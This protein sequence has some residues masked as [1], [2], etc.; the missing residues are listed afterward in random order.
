MVQD[1][2]MNTPFY[3]IILSYCTN[4]KISVFSRDVQNVRRHGLISMLFQYHS[5]NSIYYDSMEHG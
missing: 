2:K 3:N 4:D 1:N 5:E